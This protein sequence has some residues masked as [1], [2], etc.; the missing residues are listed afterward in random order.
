MASLITVIEQKQPTTHTIYCEECEEADG[1]PAIVNI[2]SGNLRLCELHFKALAL[3][4]TK[5]V[6]GLS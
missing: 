4:V 6:R 3:N 1:D 2:G 5:F